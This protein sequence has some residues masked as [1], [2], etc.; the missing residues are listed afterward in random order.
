MHAGMEVDSRAVRSADR[1]PRWRYRR[2]QRARTAG[3]P[4]AD[5][6]G[7]AVDHDGLPLAERPG[8][9]GG[10]K[11]NGHAQRP[12]GD[13]RV[14]KRCA[15]D[16]DKRLRTLNERAELPVCHE[17]DMAGPADGAATHHA[18]GNTRHICDTLDPKT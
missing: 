13:R 7:H 18:R 4:G 5:H 12:L 8:L 15:V 1:S 16:D 14:G 2:R 9:R 10:D 6:P 11:D 17:G 3:R